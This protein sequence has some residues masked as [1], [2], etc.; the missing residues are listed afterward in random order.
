MLDQRNINSIKEGRIVPPMD[1]NDKSCNYSQTFFSQ[2][3]SVDPSNK[4]FSL[5]LVC[6]TLTALNSVVLTDDIKSQSKPCAVNMKEDKEEDSLLYN[7][8]EVIDNVH[9]NVERQAIELESP[10]KKWVKK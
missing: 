4:Q 7:F 1:K 2:Q 10:D 3:L 6:T 9:N 5:G 8:Q